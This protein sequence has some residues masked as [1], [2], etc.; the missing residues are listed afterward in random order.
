LQKLRVANFS[1]S[2]DGFG[3]GPSQDMNNPLGVGGMNLHQ[4]FFQTDAFKKMH[5]DEQ[6]ETGKDNDYAARGFKNTGAWIIGR[7]MFGP[8]RG[9]W[10][11]DNWKGWWGENPPY[12]CPVYVLTNHARKSIS[13]E[14]GTVFHFVTDGIEAA[15]KLAK[16]SANGKDV[17]LGG[18]VSTVRQYLTAKLIDELH[19]TISPI[20]LGSGERLFNDINLLELGYKCIESALT[21]KAMHI[22]LAKDQTE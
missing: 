19:I 14:G 2:V 9:N 12:H 18:G 16:Q 13:M 1:I 8:I 21:E 3:A 15:L 4:W 20:I 7:N 11:D 5:G 6:G 22:I 17:I 10:P